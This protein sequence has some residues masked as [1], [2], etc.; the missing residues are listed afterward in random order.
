MKISDEGLELIRQYEGFRAEAYR[1]PA[2][3]WT[4]GY[5]HT[6]PEVR[7]G[8]K[9]DTAKAVELLKQDVAGAEHAVVR[10][11]LC[12]NQHQFDALVSFVFNVGAGNFRNSRLLQVVRANPASPEVAREMARWNKAGGVVLPGL[13]RRREAE[14]RLYFKTENY[15]GYSD[16]NRVRIFSRDG[17]GRLAGGTAETK[18]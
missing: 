14:I 16:N 18:K 17:P 10:E 9:V 5:G 13:I 12:L 1:C 2:G 15:G 6:G 3:V 8:M 4:I 11:A 7:K